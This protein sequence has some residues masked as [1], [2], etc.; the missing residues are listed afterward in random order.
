MNKD[1]SQIDTALDK[2]KFVELSEREKIQRI[3][4]II[5]YAEKKLKRRFP[6][7][8][9]QNLL[10]ALIIAYSCL[11]FLLNSY[12]FVKGIIPAWVCIV[13]NAF[14][15]S[16]LHEMEHDLIHHIYFKTKPAVQ[17]FFMSIIWLFRGNLISPWY[18]KW[19][20]LVHHRESGQIVDIEERLIGNGMPYGF[21][22]FITMFDTSLSW[23]NFNEMKKQI[24]HF[25]VVDILKATFPIFIIFNVI[26]FSFLAH[27]GWKFLGFV[28]DVVPP[29]PTW[30]IGLVNFLMVI[31]VA[32][33]MLRQF[34]LSLVSSSCHYYGDI[35]KGDLLKQVQVLKPWFLFPFQL[36]CF[37]FG[38]THVIHHFV[39]NQ[40]FY[41]RQLVAPFAHAAMKKYGV[42]FNDLS[43]FLTGNRYSQAA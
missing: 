23:I 2:N 21:R 27:Q 1:N 11:A 35:K 25:K 32:P 41:L 29:F 40:P 31:Y 43:T 33:N 4:S 20:H 3:S 24:P 39:V 5:K 18:R 16:F 26:W 13:L 17:N 38:S 14:C 10:G 6:I 36:F 19:I 28:Q 22:R 15:T 7:L 37:N 9:K 30:Y 42:R 34:S 12:L 8:E